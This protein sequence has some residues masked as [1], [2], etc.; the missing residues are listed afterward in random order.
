M[1]PDEMSLEEQLIASIAIANH[2]KNMEKLVFQ[3]NISETIALKYARGKR[4]ESRYSEYEVY[5]SL[6]DGRAMYATP[7][8]DAK[9]TACSPGEGELFTV[10]KREIK[11][12][13]KKRIEW[14]VA[15]ATDAATNEEPV[16]QERAAAP[17]AA[18]KSTPHA[19]AVPDAPILSQQ[20]LA[21]T[22]AGALIAAIDALAVARDYGKKKG[23]ALEFN[24]EDVRTC[25]A[26]L[27]IAAT[28]NDAAVRVT[29]AAAMQAYQRVN[30][31]VQ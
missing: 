21:Q 13:Q 22:M 29:G 10:C 11:D 6:T 2:R 26:S 4:V 30:G 9:I 3:T 25:A 23:F 18:V 7:A 5:Y 28:K 31:G 17:V 20:P 27:F 19:G 12:G 1:R 15:L 16:R 24:E 8:L 14:Q